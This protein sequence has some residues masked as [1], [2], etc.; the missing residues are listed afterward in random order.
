MK[1]K[2]LLGYLEVYLS[3]DRSKVAVSKPCR[4]PFTLII[5]AQGLKHWHQTLSTGTTI[6]IAALAALIQT[7][8]Q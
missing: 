1:T 7:T 4:E 3:L 2:P 5:A 8:S 6:A